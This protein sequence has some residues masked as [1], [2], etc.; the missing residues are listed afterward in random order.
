MDITSI[1]VAVFTV[2]H[3]KPVA[4]WSETTQTA[5]R[6]FPRLRQ[7]LFSSFCHHGLIEKQTCCQVHYCPCVSNTAAPPRLSTTQQ[8]EAVRLGPL[9]PP[10]TSPPFQTMQP[11]APPQSAGLR[12]P[13]GRV[14]PLL[15]APAHHLTGLILFCFRQS[16][17]TKC[18]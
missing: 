12:S 2:H 16:L 6:S 13:T 8:T 18:S 1:A 3:P 5:Q 14:S 7:E 17:G 9:H 10:Q 11:A 15:L 4:L